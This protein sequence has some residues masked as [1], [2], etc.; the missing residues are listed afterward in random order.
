VLEGTGISPAAFWFPQLMGN[1]VHRNSVL[2]RPGKLQAAFTTV[3]AMVAVLVCALVFVS[4]YAGFSAGFSIVQLTREN[5]RATQILGEKMETIRLYRWDQITNSGF[6]PTNFVDC[7]YP[8]AT[9]SAAGLSFTGRVSVVP[10]PITEFYSSDLLQ[11]T[12]DLQWTSGN[13]QRNRQSTTFVS[14]YG[15]QHYIY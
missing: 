10:A 7:F 9:Q 11:V 12:I 2:S 15:L 3:E 6:M 13:V 4:L 5:L 14:K 8:L 1:I